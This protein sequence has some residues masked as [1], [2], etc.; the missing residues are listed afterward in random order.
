VS[1]YLLQIVKCEQTTCCAA[2]AAFR[3]SWM[4]VFLDRFL[5]AHLLVSHT[6]GQLF[7]KLMMSE[8]QTNSAN[9]DAI[10]IDINVT[11]YSH[12]VRPVLSTSAI[13]GHPLSYLPIWQ[14]L[15]AIRCCCKSTPSTNSCVTPELS[16]SKIFALTSDDTKDCVPLPQHAVDDAVNP[17][18]T[19]RTGGGGLKKSVFVQTS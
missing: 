7:Q 12:S 18:W 2:C 1:Q 16:A 14:Y 5:P 10:E 17:I 19:L 9:C 4:Q 8:V 11:I 15:H 6:E 13:K 3:T